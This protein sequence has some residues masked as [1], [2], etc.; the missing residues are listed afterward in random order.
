VPT[1][2]G[3]T[4]EGR[5]EL[6]WTNKSLRL[7]ADE[8]GRYEWLPPADYRIAEVRLLHA[9]NEI[10][11]VAADADRACDNLLIRGDALNALTSLIE[12]PELAR[13]YV[14]KV[15][16]AYLD[17]PFNTQ[18]SFLQYD[19]ALEHSVWLTMMRD[20]LLSIKTLLAP[21]GSVWVHCDDSEQAYLKVM[22][23]EVFGRENFVASVVWQKIHARNNSAQHFS[24]D[25]DY[26]VA[27]AKNRDSWA[28][29]RVSRTQ[30]SDGDFWN[31]DDD[32]RGLWRRSDL[33]ASHAYAEGKYEVVG[34]H[35]EVFVPRES[36]ILSRVVDRGMIRQPSEPPRWRCRARS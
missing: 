11:D 10:G 7:L 3:R 8:D 35:G 6:T 1:D 18:Q 13:E 36:E 9:R 14:G 21:D 30:L 22:M 34:P 15:K 16:L 4:H 31:P 28:R 27:F 23:D 17:P 24:T 5:L 33:T 25:H 2:E 29:N 12:L 26:I 20:R 32:S 19:D